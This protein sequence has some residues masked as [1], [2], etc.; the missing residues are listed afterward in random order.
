VCA[1]R[2]FGSTLTEIIGVLAT[3]GTQFGSSRKA[4][5]AVA[6]VAGSKAR[7]GLAT[8]ACQLD[9]RPNGRAPLFDGV[10]QLEPGHGRGKRAETREGD[11]LLIG[12]TV[13]RNDV[14]LPLAGVA[15]VGRRVDDRVISADVDVGAAARTQHPLD[16]AFVVSGSRSDIE[17]RRRFCGG[18]PCL[19]SRRFV[20]FH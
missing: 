8:S 13:C 15:M 7:S 18:R 6:L 9:V 4:S 11:C 17:P 5:L 2:N 19:E 20:D 3:A 10:G 16:A 14:E 1:D 12:K